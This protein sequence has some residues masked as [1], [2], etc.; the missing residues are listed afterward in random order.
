[1]A[2]APAKRRR[3]T[4]P[5]APAKVAP[6]TPFQAWVAF[7]RE[8]GE[9]LGIARS[10]I[11]LLYVIEATGG[12]PGNM[13]LYEFLPV[14]IGFLLLAPLVLLYELWLLWARL[15]GIRRGDLV[16]EGDELSAPPAPLVAT[17][18]GRNAKARAAVRGVNHHFWRKVA[19]V[20]LL[21]VAAI[22]AQGFVLWLDA[23]AGLPASR[24]GWLTLAALLVLL[25]FWLGAEIAERR[26]AIRR[27]DGAGR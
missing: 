9:I 27:I 20:G 3:A 26:D 22:G 21:F 1:M 15:R 4:R 11:A 17:G 25:V 6:Q 18:R 24:Q 7:A 2:A 13:R 14:A 10:I 5:R 19:L 12:S 16:V 23:R 8:T